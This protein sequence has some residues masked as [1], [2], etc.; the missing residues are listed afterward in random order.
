LF[1]TCIFRFSGIDVALKA[2]LQD[3][4][5]NDDFEQMH[6]SISV[7]PDTAIDAKPDPQSS[8][9]FHVME[10]LGSKGRRLWTVA[11]SQM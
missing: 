4:K 11:S 7:L 3:C 1:R 9:M 8:T 2:S 5:Y 6:R 10:Y